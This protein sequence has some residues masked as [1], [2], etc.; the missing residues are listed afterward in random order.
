MTKTLGRHLVEAEFA[1]QREIGYDLKHDLHHMSI[2]DNGIGDFLDA[3]YAYQFDSTMEW[4]WSQDTFKS[5]NVLRNLVKA[6]ALYMAAY[7]LAKATG[8]YSLL[9]VIQKRHDYVVTSIDEI[10]DEARKALDV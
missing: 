9:T 8:Q 3:A 10:L 6:G 4:P 7:D 1:R 5:T 2:S